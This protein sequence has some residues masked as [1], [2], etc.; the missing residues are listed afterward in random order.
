MVRDFSGYIKRMSLI[1]KGSSACLNEAF[2]DIR[3][4]RPQIV[5][6]DVKFLSA[7]DADLKLIQQISFLVV[8]SDRIEDAFDAFESQAFD[9]LVKP[10]SYDR[11][12]RGIEKY[13]NLGVHPSVTSKDGTFDLINNAFFIKIDS[14]ETKEVLVKYSDLVFVQGLQNYIVLHLENGV[15]HLSYHTMKRMEEKLPKSL[16][17]RIHKSY[18]INHSKITSI[19]STCVMLNEKWK[20]NI[21]NA[22]RKTFISKKTAFFDKS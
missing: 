12:I 6:I 7:S 11:F 9:Y 1:L 14:K 4:Y 3:V 19:E 2:E 5:Y 20:L 21:G 15:Y 16:F 17:T 10:I 13:N 8:V 18:L 22:Y